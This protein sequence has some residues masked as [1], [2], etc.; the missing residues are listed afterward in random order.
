MLSDSGFAPRKEIFCPLFNVLE[1]LK[2]L[3]SYDL[4]LHAIWSDK[5]KKKRNLLDDTKSALELNA[6]GSISL[7]TKYLIKMNPQISRIWL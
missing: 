1:P 4:D 3:K 2:S 6:I 7:T 5:I